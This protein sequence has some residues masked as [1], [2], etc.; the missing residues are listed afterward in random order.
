[1]PVSVPVPVLSVVVEPVPVSLSC[2]V[3]PSIVSKEVVDVA[4]VEDV[5]PPV[6][7]PLT[8]VVSFSDSKG[9]MVPQA[10]STTDE[11]QTNDNLEDDMAPMYHKGHVV[12]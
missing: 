4:C 2:V 3:E 1:V 10:N 11:A 8:P 7:V 12:F 6:H 9:G 5:S